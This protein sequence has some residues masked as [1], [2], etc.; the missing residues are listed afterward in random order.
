MFEKVLV[1][2]RGEIAVRIIR[3]LK[4]MGLKSVAVYSEADADAPHTWLADEA[5]PIGPPEPPESYLNIPRLMEAARRTGAQA[6]HP[7]YGFLSEN[8]AFAEACEKAGL[9]FI[10]PPASAMRQAGDKAGSKALARKVGVPVTPG[11]DRCES[12]EEAERFAR[13]VGFP[14]LLKASGGGGGK[15]MR[16]VFRPEDLREAF[17]SARR[18]ALHAFGDP[19]LLVERFIHPARHIEVQVIADHRGRV[20]ALGEREC[21]LQRRYQKIVEEAPSPFVTPDLRQRLLESAQRLMSAVG[22]RNAGTVEFLVG[23]DGEF[24]FM[25][26][27][28]RLQVEHPVTEMVLGLDLVRLQVEV[29][30]G[31]PLPLEGA[32][33]PRGHAI[34]ARLYAEDPARDF[35]PSPGRVLALHWPHL[36]GVRVDSGLREGLEVPPY[37]DPMVAKIIAW[38]VDREQARRRLVQA[39]RETVVLGV[40]TNQS[41]LIDLLESPAMVRG[42][43]T[44]TTVS[45]WKWT[46]P[47]PDPLALLGGALAL[48]REGR[49]PAR[50]A[51]PTASGAQVY[52]PWRVLGRFR[53]LERSG[54]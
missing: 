17:E 40:V 13:E 3:T 21:S 23:P 47:E 38:G 25:E 53:L 48:A 19:G 10:G 9:V 45:E 24:Y 50:E 11:S 54:F 31:L 44:T 51:V 5:V 46:P 36:P 12:L 1:A 28:A 7:G 16:K 4:E 29:A 8:P 43:T 18:E 41:F 52:S 15:G 35:L 20:L 14:L 26:I 27:N 22:Y 39:L 32:P 33:Q 6:V 42:E 2:N 30:M 37:Y 49:R 34:E